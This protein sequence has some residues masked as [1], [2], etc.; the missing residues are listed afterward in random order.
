MKQL[1]NFLFT[2]ILLLSTS[3]FADTPTPEQ[4]H[5]NEVL[6]SLK[7]VVGPQKVPAGANATFNVDKGYMFLDSAD[8][9]RIMELMQNLSSGKEYFF[10]PDDMHWFSVFEFE[11]IGY[12]KDD[13]K[14]D[15]E[16]LLA[17]IQAGTEEANK[18]KRSRGWPTMTIVGWKYPPR[19]DTQT[20]QLEW[21]I[22]ARDEKNNQI[23]N[24]NTRLLGRH[25][26]TSVT[27]VVAPDK[28]DAAVGEFKAALKG[29]EFNTGGRYQ[30]FAP[31]DKVAE[32][33]LAA[34]VA[35]G[36]AA[37]LVKSGAGKWIWKLLAAGGIAALAGL[38]AFFGRKKT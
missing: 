21:A 1:Q 31:G 6:K 29:Y 13:E 19:Y 8:T 18:E 11:D 22:D 4:Q 15:A 7:W 37:A 26:V 14:I 5:A 38:K 33:G 12:V 24:F 30:E 28:L 25:G 36:T 10:S 17:S 27:L 35:G 9:K 20:K 23:V 32:Y 16:A 34:L 3:V 2:I